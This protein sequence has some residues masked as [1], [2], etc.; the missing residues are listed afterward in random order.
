MACGNMRSEARRNGA[1]RR[2]AGLVWAVLLTVAAAGCSDDDDPAAPQGTVDPPVEETVEL[3]LSARGLDDQPLAADGG[4]V[5]QVAVGEAFDL[6]LSYVDHR[7]EAERLGASQLYVDLLADQ[8]GILAPV[9]AETFALVVGGEVRA[10]GAPGTVV[11]GIEGSATSHE[12]DAVDFVADPLAALSEALTSFGYAQ[13]SDYRL[14]PMEL[15][16][17]DIGIRIRWDRDEYGNVDMPDPFVTVQGSSQPVSTQSIEWGPFNPDG[18]PNSDAIRFNIDAR[19]R[20]ISGEGEFYAVD[21]R[22]AFDPAT[23]FRG[24]GGRGPD[25]LDGVTDVTGILPRP[26]D[27]FSLRVRLLSPVAGLTVT[28]SPAD[29]GDAVL[30]YGLEGAVA[31]E[32]IRTDGDHVVTITATAA[33]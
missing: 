1:H 9:L 24:V 22:G 12:T 3:V 19:S 20:S 33:R 14:E 30:M 27:A 13:G 23:G 2:L 26:F 25:G 8:A 31:A 5:I 17:D 28:A 18:T 4:G 29:A 21:N 16:G 7:E 10:G 11:F 6:E 15:I 32:D